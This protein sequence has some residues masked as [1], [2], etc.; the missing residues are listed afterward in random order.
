MSQ[1]MS[2]PQ[3]KILQSICAAAGRTGVAGVQGA[4]YLREYYAG[5]PPQDLASRDARELAAAALDQLRFARQRT[6]GRARVRVFNPTVREHGYDSPHTVVEMVGDDMPFLVD[7]IGLPFLRRG[8]TLHFLAHPIFAVARDAK[9]ALRSLRPRGAAD[10]NPR[11]RLESFQHVEIDRIVDAATLES[12]TQEIERNLRD[13]R[14]ACADWSKMQAAARKAADDLLVERARFDRA[15]RARRAS[16]WSGWSTA[17]SRFSAIANTACAAPAAKYPSCRSKRADSA[18]C[19][20]AIG[21]PSAAPT[22]C[23]ATYGAKAARANWP[24]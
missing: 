20:A 9:G 16:S 7:S 11:A 2:E 6:R 14:V 1:A 17:I 5:V 13:V 24:W 12:L 18:S 23:R 19:A 22:H 3:K 15:T 10:G 4:S 8:L 21:A